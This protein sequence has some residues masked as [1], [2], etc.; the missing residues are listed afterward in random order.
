MN[1][2]QMTEEIVA[3]LTE[4]LK[5][6]PDFNAAILRNKIK[7]AVRELKL[8]RNYN[9]SNMSASDIDS[10]IVNY[11]SVILNVARYDYNQRGAEGET[12]H[13]ENGVARTY[14][15]R[16]ALWRSVHAYVRVL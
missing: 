16:D 9:D 3:D 5:D 1:E 2:I 10:D 13:S 12:H 8:K 6:D 11:Y 4:E 15:S 7:A 14:E